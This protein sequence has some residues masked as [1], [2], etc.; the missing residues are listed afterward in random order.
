MFAVTGISGKVGGTVARTLLGRGLQVRAVLRDAQK[1]RHWEM[2]GC[3]IALAQADDEAALTG[4]F[5]DVDGVF[6]MQPPDYDP[7]P[8]FPKIVSRCAAMRAALCRTRPRKVVYLSTV[9][10]HVAQPNLLNNA[11]ITEDMLRGTGLPVCMLRAA[12]FM[13]NASRDVDA[14]RAGQID[15]FLQPLHHPVPMVA[16]L[17]IGRNAAQILQEEWAGV[18][19]VELEGPARYSA[20]DIAA[21]FGAALG[22]TVRV[23]AVPRDTWEALF[24]SQGMQH[25]GARIRMLDGFNE[26]WV[27]FERGAGMELRRGDTPLDAV[28]ATLVK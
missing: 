22:K 6:L 11:K 5:Q 28:L 20:N 3:E 19:V 13:E 26:G 25:P 4:A 2:Q 24:R 21:G 10:A 8:G 16:T 1:A 15:S 23:R 12:W 9:G 18:R 7:A 27:D 14:A 17:D